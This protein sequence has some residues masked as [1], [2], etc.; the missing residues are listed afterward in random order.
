[1]SAV[2]FAPDGRFLVATGAAGR[3][4]FW[5]V[6]KFET[7]LYLY[8]FGPGAWLALLSDGRFDGALDALRYLCYTERGSF[9]SFTAEELQKEFYDPEAVQ[10]VLAKCTS[11][12]P[13]SS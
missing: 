6:E 4:Q 5:D 10:E 13:T 9:N 11:P 2:R 7:F 1:V 12:S 8:A 3:L